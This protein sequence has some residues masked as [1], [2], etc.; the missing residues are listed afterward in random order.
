MPDS[1]EE[2]RNTR[3]LVIPT[4]ELFLHISRPVVAIFSSSVFPELAR[5]SMYTN[6]VAE[7]MQNLKYALTT[8]NRPIFRCAAS[9]MTYNPIPSKKILPLFVSFLRCSAP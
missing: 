1:S 2:F 9:P 6:C 8:H 5:E 4:S 3:I 7:G